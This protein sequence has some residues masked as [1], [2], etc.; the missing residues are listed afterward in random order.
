MPRTAPDEYWRLTLRELLI[1]AGTTGMR[2]TPILH[3][4]VHSAS[5]AEINEQLE[6]WLEEGKVQKFTV[7]SGKKGGRPSQVW[8]ATT[9]MLK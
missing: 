6:E 1:D 2:I 7:P 3:R 5:S 8:R 4:F 9:E